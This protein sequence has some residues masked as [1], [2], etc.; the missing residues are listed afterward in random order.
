M[1]TLP[2]QFL[3][4]SIRLIAAKS[5]GCMGMVLSNAVAHG[6]NTEIVYWLA[7]KAPATTVDAVFV[8]G[9]GIEAR[10]HN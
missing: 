3:K 5:I 6:H 1:K 8:V 4:R 10:C 7:C 2:V 9:K